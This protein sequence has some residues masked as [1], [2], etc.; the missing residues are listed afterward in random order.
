MNDF[1][2]QVFCFF[3]NVAACVHTAGVFAA[4]EADVTAQSRSSTATPSAWTHGGFSSLWPLQALTQTPPPLHAR[5]S[6]LRTPCAGAYLICGDW[7]SSD[8]GRDGGL[9]NHAVGGDTVRRGVEPGKR[10]TW[11]K[12]PGEEDDK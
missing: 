10:R 9:C 6:G 12:S 2:F 8:E 1:I 11:K 3:L 7:R 5:H 4:Y